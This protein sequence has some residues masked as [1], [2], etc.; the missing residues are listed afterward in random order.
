[1]RE[2]KHALNSWQEKLKESDN[3][4]DLSK[5]GDRSRVLKQGEDVW[6]SFVREANKVDPIGT[7]QYVGKHP[8][9]LVSSYCTTIPHHKHH[10]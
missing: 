6:T 5:S 3:L 4:E 10:S 8:G 1:M 9:P 7:W 2:Q